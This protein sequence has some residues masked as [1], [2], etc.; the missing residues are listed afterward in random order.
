RLCKG[1]GWVEDHP[2]LRKHEGTLAGGDLAQ[3]PPDD[4]LGMAEPVDGGR[5]DPVD[6]G[7]DRVPD[8]RDRGLVVLASPAVGATT[9]AHGP[10]ADTDLGDLKA[11]RSELTRQP[12]PEASTSP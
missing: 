4:F 8:G 7:C 9:T 11:A 6:G 3:R 2:A 5:I 10:R 12:S 1:L